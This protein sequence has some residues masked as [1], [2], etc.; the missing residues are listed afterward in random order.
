MNSQ[1]TIPA[2]SVPS[3]DGGDDHGDGSLNLNGLTGDGDGTNGV[4][5]DQSAFGSDGQGGFGG[6]DQFGGHG[7]GA[8]GHGPPGGESGGGV[9]GGQP[10]GDGGP[11]GNEGPPPPPPPRGKKLALACHFCRRRKLKSVLPSP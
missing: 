3:H 2:Y 11:L 8:Y 5:G 7:N 1:V 6:D 10:G 9:D 4:Y